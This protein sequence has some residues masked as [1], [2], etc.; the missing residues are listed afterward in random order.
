MVD[1]NKRLFYLI[2]PTLLFALALVFIFKTVGII[3]ALMLTL[4][5]LPLVS[6]TILSLIEHRD[7]TVS[8]L[9]SEL[10]KRS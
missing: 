6:V 7:S 5:Y 1:Y 9:R 10:Y 3:L 4:F 2:A 8:D